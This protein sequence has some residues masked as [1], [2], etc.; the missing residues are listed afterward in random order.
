MLGLGVGELLLIA[1]V[2]L[3]VI[4]PS[5]LPKFMRSAGQYYGQIR[6]MADEMRRALVLEAD[7]QDADERYRSMMKRRQKAEA[8]LKKAERDSPGVA[9]QAHP[10]ETGS[11]NGFEEGAVAQGHEQ[12][13]EKRRLIPDYPGS[14]D[15]EYQSLVDD[16]HGPYS[17]G[18]T[19]ADLPPPSSSDVPIPGFS[20]AEWAEL[21]PKVRAALRG[22]PPGETA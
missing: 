20:Q 17:A 4:P 7:R 14:D 16:P 18:R 11:Q 2:V 13:T 8:D 3:V 6:R 10:F 9:P 15:F 19:L 5:S 22:R 12:A 21:P 1:V